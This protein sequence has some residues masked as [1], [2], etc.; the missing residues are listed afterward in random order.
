[1][2]SP[3]SPRKNKLLKLS[4]FCI[5][6][7]IILKRPETQKERKTNTYRRSWWRQWDNRKSFGETNF[8][9]I[10]IPN[11]YLKKKLEVS[12]AKAFWLQR[13]FPILLE[14]GSFYS[15]TAIRSK[16]ATIVSFGCDTFLTHFD[17]A[18]NVFSF[19]S[20]WSGQKFII[21]STH[22]RFYDIFLNLF[23][24]LIFTTFKISVRKYGGASTEQKTVFLDS[25]PLRNLLSS[26]VF[27]SW[28]GF[29]GCYKCNSS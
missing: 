2:L 25:H 29:P 27:C 24:F 23:F 20:R 28:Y 17:V 19:H 11:V 13:L 18:I 8:V 26:N 10:F 4:T 7:S 21:Q 14:K 22:S 16:L 5:N 12:A 9:H 6:H 3:E 15:R 1:M